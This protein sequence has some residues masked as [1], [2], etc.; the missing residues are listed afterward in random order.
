[1]KNGTTPDGRKV[2]EPFAPGQINA[3]KRQK[4]CLLPLN[5][6]A[7]IRYECNCEDGVSNTVTI[8][9]NTLGKSEKERIN[10]LTNI[11]DGYFKQGA[12]HLN[13]N[14]LNKETLQDAMKNPE[15]Y[16]LLT[17]RVSGYAVRFNRLNKHQQEEV[18]A[19]TFHS[20]I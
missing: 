20:K 13:V 2:G 4:Q 15:N 18:I 11:L 14:V 10:N 9:P 8:D 16:P 5:S 17:I 7:K 6:V 19:R 1:M 12:H 3:R